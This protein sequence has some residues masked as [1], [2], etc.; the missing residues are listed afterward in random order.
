MNVYKVH[1][2]DA[3]A[4]RIVQKY[5]ELGDKCKIIDRFEKSGLKN[6]FAILTKIGSINFSTTGDCCGVLVIHD[7]SVH[8]YKTRNEHAELLLKIA[9]SVAYSLG[10]STVQYITSQ[11]Q[12]HVEDALKSAGWEAVYT[13]NNARTNHS[14]TQWFKSFG[15]PL[16]FDDPRPALERIHVF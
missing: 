6:T 13:S 5:P 9:E 11:F 15:L 10:Y 16:E 4:A 12:L 7:L 2:L 1:L 8:S 14:L 3:I